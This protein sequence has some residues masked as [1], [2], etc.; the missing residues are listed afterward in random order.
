[1]RKCILLPLAL[2][3][4]VLAFTGSAH[5]SGQPLMKGLMG[6]ADL[7]SRIESSISRDPSGNSHIDERACS[8]TGSCATPYMY[9]YGINKSHSSARL[10]GVSELPR[11]LRSLSQR[12]A[13]Q[14]EWQMSRILVDTSGS[15]YDATGWHR[16]FAPGESVWD[17][18]N[19]G[20]HILAGDCGNVVGQQVTGATPTVAQVASGP[21]GGCPNGYVL[22]FNAWSIPSLSQELQQLAM[23]LVAEARARDT[24]QAA[25]PSGYQ[26]RDFSRT[27][28]YQLR[29]EVRQRAL[30]TTRVE[31]NYRDPQ[32]RQVTHRLGFMAVF[33]GEGEMRL[34]DD[35]RA[36]IVE[37]IVPGE[38]V[39]VAMSGG[40]RRIWD[41]PKEWNYPDGQPMCKQYTHGG[42]LS[43][44]MS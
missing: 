44:L 1:M 26:G 37:L 35:P 30:V 20:E 3:L 24:Q 12:K 15:R 16:A 19:T 27:L 25:D 39:T 7:A 40:Q 32:T 6:P 34:P 17:D 9:Y 22:A 23:Q 10:G 18:P 31:V 2:A 21:I 13:P 14:G 29:H 4:A 11:Y 38:F 8:E 33:A 36:H 41:F 5:A 43:D 42:L 28:G